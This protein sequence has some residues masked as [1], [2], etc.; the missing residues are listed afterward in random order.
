MVNKQNQG[1]AR[2]EIKLLTLLKDSPYVVNIDFTYENEHNIYMVLEYCKHGCMYDN[3]TILREKRLRQVLTSMLMCILECHKY[4][5]LHGDIKFTNFVVDSN[6][7]TKLI[8]FGCSKMVND[9]LDCQQA[10][11]FYAAPENMQS[12]KYMQSDMWSLGVCAYV[13]ATGKHPFEYGGKINIWNI[14]M[15][16]KNKYWMQ[17]S[18]DCQDFIKRLLE[19]DYKLR[20]TSLDAMYHPFIAS[21]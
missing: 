17:L 8:D 6:L 18:M 13:M 14:K 5:I 10:T 15:D 3:H 16:T 4:N 19:F 20:M 12:T 1:A 21:E 7:N 11:W 9:V 2:N